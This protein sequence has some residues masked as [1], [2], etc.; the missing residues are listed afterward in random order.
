MI[1]RMEGVVMI[2]SSKD[3]KPSVAQNI[4]ELTRINSFGGSNESSQSSI[5]CNKKIENC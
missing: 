4:Q 3:R 1:E 2:I 5:V